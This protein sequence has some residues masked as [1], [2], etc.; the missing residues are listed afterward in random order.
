MMLE[1]EQ[2]DLLFLLV[3]TARS[4]PRDKRDKFHLIEVSGESF[5]KHWALPNWSPDCYRGDIEI[6]GTNGLLNLQMNSDGDYIFD[7]LPEAFAYYQKLKGSQDQPAIAAEQSVRHYLLDQQFEKKY[8]PALDRWI[9]AE[10]KLWSADSNK[11]LT[12]IGLLCREAVQEFID[13]L[14]RFH[15]VPNIDP[16]KS[17][18][19]ARLKSLIKHRS[20]SMSSAVSSFLESLLA[21]YGSL[22]DLIQRQVHG[23][24][25]EGQQLQWEDARRIVFQAS[26]V[27]YEIER[28]FNLIPQIA[29]A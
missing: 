26:I 14:V 29:T 20:P 3:E 18:T 17:H 13:I 19:I 24:S 11:E 21:Y 16:D 25:K 8:K 6:L 1:Q 27:M 23:G 10:K 28:S 7:L 22:D 5:L 4:I 15:G 9:S 12:T 2:I